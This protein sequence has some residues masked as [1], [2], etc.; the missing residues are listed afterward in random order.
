MR[1]CL[2]EEKLRDEGGRVRT[3]GVYGGKESWRGI[4]VP[5]GV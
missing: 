2:L 5:A 4:R 3:S 1:V